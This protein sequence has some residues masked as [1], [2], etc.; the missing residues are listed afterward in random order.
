MYDKI[1]TCIELGYSTILIP[2]E[3][4]EVMY[5]N[6]LLCSLMIGFSSVIKS[7]LPQY[8]IG[9]LIGFSDSFNFKIHGL[10]N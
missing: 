3:T 8:N 1:W 9:H 5:T 7:S 6:Q 4:F 10:I 2:G